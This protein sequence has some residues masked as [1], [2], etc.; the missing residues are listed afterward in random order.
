MPAIKI[1]PLDTDLPKLYDTFLCAVGFETRARNVAETLH[2]NASRRHAVG[3]QDRHALAYSTN[4]S[5]FIQQG[6]HYGEMSDHEFD[7]FLRRAVF[8]RV[9]DGDVLRIA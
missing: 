6:F 3:F 9:G 4:R 8:A 7:S 1:Q 2:I 5:W